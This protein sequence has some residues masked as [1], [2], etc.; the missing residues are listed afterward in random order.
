[1]MDFLK[2]VFYVL[3]SFGFGLVAFDKFLT[4]DHLIN[5]LFAGVCAFAAIGLMMLAFDY[6]DNGDF[7]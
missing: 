5:Y 3:A 6:P 2:T 4:T 1:M 7:R